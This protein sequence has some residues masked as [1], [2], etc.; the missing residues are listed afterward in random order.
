MDGF[1]LRT[2]RQLQGDTL[3]TFSKKAGISFGFLSQL[4]RNNKRIGPVKFVQ[5]CDA[6]NLPADDRVKLLKPADRLRLQRDA[7]VAA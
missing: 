7:E 5:I 3:A 4:E 1:K 6:L 2:L